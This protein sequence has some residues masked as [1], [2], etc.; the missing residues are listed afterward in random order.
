MAKDQT[1]FSYLFGS[2]TKEIFAQVSSA[3][4]RAEL[5]PPLRA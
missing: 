3:T 4:T 2:L 1:V 5:W